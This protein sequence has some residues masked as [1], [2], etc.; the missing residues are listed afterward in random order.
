MR[1]WVQV[2]GTR[3]GARSKLTA[4][5]PTR[6]PSTCNTQ[7]QTRDPA[8]LWQCALCWSHS[9]CHTQRISEVSPLCV[10]VVVFGVCH[11]SGTMS[12][13]FCGTVSH[14]WLPTSSSNPPVS[15]SPELGMQMH[16]ATP[17][18]VFYDRIS[19]CD[20]P[21]TLARLALT[22]AILLPLPLKC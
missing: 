13:A 6:N 12:L 9:A 11:S 21:G 10:F 8:V 18:L 17:V 3:D 4:V 1:A 7:C 16:T 14:R 20:L 22:S 5:G 15:A 2:P 19:S